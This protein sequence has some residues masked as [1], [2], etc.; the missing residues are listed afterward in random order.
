MKVILIED[1]EGLGK[2][3]EI[4]EVKSG[5]ARNFLLP[6]NLAKRATKKTVEWSEI[7]KELLEKEA[8]EELK[9][10]QELASAID[11]FEVTILVKVGEEGQLFESIGQQ[12]I[13]EKLK[14]GGF[15]VKKF[16]IDLK[17]PIKELGEFPIKINLEHNLEAEIKAIIVEEKI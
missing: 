16:Q 17:E 10:I 8:E 13:S 1:I 14:E 9:K 11:G 7:Q 5:Y 3:Y 15:E 12:K 4:K 2:K 6:K